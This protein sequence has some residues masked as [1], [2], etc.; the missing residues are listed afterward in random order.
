[1]F[2]EWIWWKTYKNYLESIS[3]KN[4]FY[5]PFAT[6]PALHTHI[7][8]TTRTPPA[9]PRQ[10]TRTTGSPTCHYAMRRCATHSDETLE[11]SCKDPVPL[12]RSIC[13]TLT[14]RPCLS[15]RQSAIIG[16]HNNAKQGAKA[17]GLGVV[18]VGTPSSPLTRS[19]RVM[20]MP[21]G[22]STASQVRSK[23]SRV[24][25][26]PL[27]EIAVLGLRMLRFAILP[28]VTSSS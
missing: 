14:C 16:M 20:G 17:W 10:H 9:L 27:Y 21:L 19:R 28:F 23:A 5:H 22:I 8:A 18:A 1:M 3:A 25:R 6:L 24:V 4:F 12:P 11:W 2:R 15:Q 7:G 26:H 13:P